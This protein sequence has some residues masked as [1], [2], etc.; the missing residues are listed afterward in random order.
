MRGK[1][2][3]TTFLTVFLMIII[4]T[5][6]ALM[7]MLTFVSPKILP[8]RH[9]KKNTLE[10]FLLLNIFFPHRTTSMCVLRTENGNL[11]RLCMVAWE[12]PNWKIQL[13]C[14]ASPW[15]TTTLGIPSARKL[16]KT[17]LDGSNLQDELGECED[18]FQSPRL[19]SPLI[20]SFPPP[21]LCPWS[22]FV[23]DPLRAVYSFCT[24]QQWLLWLLGKRVVLYHCP[25][26]NTGDGTD[27]QICLWF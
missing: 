2:F 27:R 4:L 22:L 1:V 16:L 25:V 19:R 3:Y 21:A 7:G 26:T 12:I 23:M 6:L 11:Y 8:L 13:S 10:S 9:W 24:R 20:S 17:V 15:Q 5:Q 18:G 14:H